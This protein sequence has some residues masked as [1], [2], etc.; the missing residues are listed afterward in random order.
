MGKIIKKF[1]D[2][3]YLEYDRGSFDAWCVYF[4]NAA[5]YRKAPRDTEYFAQLRDLAD[6][7]GV[8]KVY[9]DYVEIYNLTGTEINED[10]LKK[11][12][13]LSRWYG[14]DATQVDIIF[15]ILY[16]AMISEER[17]AGTHLGKKIKRLGVYKLLIENRSV[18]ESADF[19]R[20]MYWKDIE[21]LCNE[22]GF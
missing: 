3:S 19:M 14:A 2:S 6:R 11:I 5:G 22:R 10:C 7:Y 9:H 17:K 15:T 1:S 8:E 13:H 20:G 4:T 12:S 21:L 16:M 18:R